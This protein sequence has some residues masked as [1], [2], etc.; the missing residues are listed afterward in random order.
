M[1]GEIFG[2]EGQKGGVELGRVV[3]SIWWD[4]LICSM[5]GVFVCLE[6]LFGW[7]VVSYSLRI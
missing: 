5:S 6:T 7:W 2:N 4:M 1:Q 3:V